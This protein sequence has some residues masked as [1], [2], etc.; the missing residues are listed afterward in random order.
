MESEAPMST[1]HHDETVVEREDAA[2]LARRWPWYLVLR[3]ARMAAI[4]GL[5]FAISLAC[6]LIAWG[7]Y[8]TARLQWIT[9]HSPGE[10]PDY[11]SL[12][13][14]LFAAL[15]FML[16][17]QVAYAVQKQLRRSEET[18]TLPESTRRPAQ[19]R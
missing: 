16:V 14:P 3:A 19:A 5:S 12:V 4:P 15:L 9:G 8:R 11:T 2:W 17:G 18:A 10:M 6:V 13:G 1:A 7:R